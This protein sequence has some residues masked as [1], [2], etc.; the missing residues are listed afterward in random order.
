MTRVSAKYIRRLA[1]QYGIEITEP[2]RSQAIKAK[3]VEL[4]ADAICQEQ[5]RIAY[6]EKVLAFQAEIE[7]A[8]GCFYHMTNFNSLMQTC[9]IRY[10][11]EKT[12]VGYIS[13][14]MLGVSYRLSSDCRNVSRPAKTAF[15]AADA[16]I[17]W[18]MNQLKHSLFPAKV[19]LGQK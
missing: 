13:Q 16:I 1:T 5:G 8:C 2:L 4:I 15:D 10:T 3:Y 14:G 12:T 19:T 6:Q 11:A 17:N 18:H 7:E 9:E